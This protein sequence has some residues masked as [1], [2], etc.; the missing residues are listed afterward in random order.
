MSE[1]Q[2]RELSYETKRKIDYIKIEGEYVAFKESI[3]LNGN[4]F[5]YIEGITTID[6]IEKVELNEKIPITSFNLLKKD[7]LEFH[8]TTPVELMPTNYL[9]EYRKLAIT[10]PYTFITN[11]LDYKDKACLVEFQGCTCN[12]VDI[13][14]KVL[15]K[16]LYFNY[17]NSDIHDGLYHLNDLFEYLKSRE[18]IKILD[19]SIIDIPH[20]HCKNGKSK[21][22]RFVW[23]PSSDDFYMA[24]SE[25]HSINIKNALEVIKVNQFKIK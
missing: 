7:V 1:R 15:P 12:L 24:Y 16:A 5:N 23:T 21:Q 17:L 25:N 11:N 9:N 14:E 6:L 3:F 4:I 18:Y 20:Y 2:Y 8:R 13:N 19:D 10:E 22:I